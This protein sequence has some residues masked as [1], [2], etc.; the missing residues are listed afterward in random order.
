MGCGMCDKACPI[1]T[2]KTE[3]IPEIEQYA[4]AAVSRDRDIRQASSSGGAFSEICRA[5]G[6]TETVV[7][8]ARFDGLRV[9]HSYVV[10]VEN[11]LPFCKSK[12]V[13]SEIEQSFSAAK[14]FLRKGS[15]VIFSGTP[16]QLAGLKS[17]LGKD[18]PQLLCIDI[19]CHGVGSPGVFACALQH[20]E[21]KAG[22]KLATFSFRNRIERLGNWQDFV[23]CYEFKDGQVVHEPNDPYQRLFLSQLCLRSSCGENCKFRKRNRLGDLTIADFKG[24]FNIFPRMMDHRNYSTIVVNSQKGNSVYRNLQ[25]SMKTLRCSLDDIERFNPLFFKTTKEN[26]HRKKFFEAYS[27]E[28][29]I[30]GLI[31]QFVPARPTWKKYVGLKDIFI[32][33]HLKRVLR[34][35]FNEFA[36]TKRVKR[37]K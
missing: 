31:R 17:Y 27:V 19:I 35:F 10:G 8:G 37:H 7:F 2:N 21:R 36:M 29:D 12:Y 34:I 18:Y 15:K 26:A 4:V 25:S 1:L 28:P 23:C 16:C 13:Q 9:V 33:F 11:I 20:I 14:K 30:D 3:T 5:Y 24:K 22:K 32:P 6:D